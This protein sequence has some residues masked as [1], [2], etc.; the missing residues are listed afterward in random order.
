MRHHS[1]QSNNRRQE[2]EFL[3][4]SARV[5]EKKRALF[6]KWKKELLAIGLTEGEFEIASKAQHAKAEVNKKVID[7]LNLQ[8]QINAI[9][10]KRGEIVAKTAKNKT[11]NGNVTVELV[12]E[13]TKP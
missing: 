9:I 3:H 6:Q 8:A 5:L 7:Y 11:L 12:K 4:R 1:P 10:Y 13:D 2:R